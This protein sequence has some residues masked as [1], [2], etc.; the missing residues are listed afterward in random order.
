[1]NYLRLIDISRVKA[2]GWAVGLMSALRYII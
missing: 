2:S 1:M